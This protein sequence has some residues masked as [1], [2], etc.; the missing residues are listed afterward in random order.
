V[1]RIPSGK[2]I[3]N[4]RRQLIV[5]ALVFGIAT[6]AAP[7]DVN[8]CYSFMLQRSGKDNQENACRGH[9]Q[10]QDGI[11]RWLNRLFPMVDEETRGNN[12]LLVLR[13]SSSSKE[14][15]SQINIAKLPNG[16]IR[17]VRY[18]LPKYL[19]NYLTTYTPEERYKLVFEPSCSQLEAIAKTILVERRV[20]KLPQKEAEKLLNNFDKLRFSPMFDDGFHW[21]GTRYDLWYFV[22]SHK[23]HYS[24]VG[25]DVGYEGEAGKPYALVD[26]M[27][28]VY[29]AVK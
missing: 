17:V 5:I 14:M 16:E 4:K 28:K 12:M 25:Q 20:V 24:I 2:K 26:W 19:D 13:Y 10:A 21:D 29:K 7:F 9:D 1:V 8:K 11:T 3:A 22:R 23:T 18:S 15:D 6:L 27:I